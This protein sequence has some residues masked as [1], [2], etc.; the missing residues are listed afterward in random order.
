MKNA[1]KKKRTVGSEEALVRQ[2]LVEV[3]ALHN[4]YIDSYAIETDFIFD[5]AN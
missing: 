3:E 5:Q 1:K 2:V 4:N